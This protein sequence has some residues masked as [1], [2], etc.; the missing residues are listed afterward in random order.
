MTTHEDRRRYT[1]LY[2]IMDTDEKVEKIS[3]DTSYWTK[4]GVYFI[5]EKGATHNDKKFMLK[6]GSASQAQLGERV[7]KY[8]FCF[9]NGFTVHALITVN[10]AEQAR[11]IEKICHSIFYNLRLQKK[12]YK[13]H[14]HVKE[15]FYLDKRTLNNMFFKVL[16]WLWHIKEIRRTDQIIYSRNGTF[17]R[18]SNWTIPQATTI[19]ARQNNQR[20]EDIDEMIENRLVPLIKSRRLEY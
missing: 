12:A 6:I 5:S 15:W 4:F 1:R 16:I 2:N 10:T 7:N 14:G 13:K 11:E 17:F 9:P 8:F 18:R 19:K 20:I 3:K